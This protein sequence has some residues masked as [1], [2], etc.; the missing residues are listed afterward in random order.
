VELAE[1]GMAALGKM[2]VAVPDLIITD[3]RMPNMD[4]FELLS[5]VRARCP[6]VATVVITG[7][8]LAADV[9][10]R[11]LAHAF[12]EKGSYSVPQFRGTIA[13]LL[14]EAGRRAA[15]PPSASARGA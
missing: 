15:S 13:D 12:F 2:E 9:N 10:G 4:G 11:V 1:D 5:R 6:G 7:E 8:F 14:A 3:L